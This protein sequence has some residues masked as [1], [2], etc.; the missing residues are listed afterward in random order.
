MAFTEEQLKSYAKEQGLVMKY[1]DKVGQIVMHVKYETTPVETWEVDEKGLWYRKNDRN[2]FLMGQKF[3]SRESGDIMVLARLDVRE[4]HIMWALVCIATGNRWT[5]P[6]WFAYDPTPDGEST[7]L[8]LASSDFFK[9]V[10][11]GTVIPVRCAISMENRI[12]TGVGERDI[13]DL[14]DTLNEF[15]VQ[16]FELSESKGDS[17]QMSYI[18][19]NIY[20]IIKEHFFF[21]APNRCVVAGC[22][23]RMTNKRDTNGILVKHCTNCG[24][25]TNARQEAQ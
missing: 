12:V 8:S 10:E 11:W 21:H 22:E 25:E 15:V 7:M 18:N 23:G 14:N 3:E 20:G 9:M 17:E 13:K 24:H 4:S 1:S 16:E 5:E 19:D 6:K 2:R